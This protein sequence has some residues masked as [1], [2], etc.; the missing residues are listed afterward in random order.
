MRLERVA[1]RHQPERHESAHHVGD[2]LDPHRAAEQESRPAP[3]QPAA[4]RGLALE[5]RLADHHV[6]PALQAAHKVGEEL[7]AVGEIGVHEDRAVALGP[8][9]PL[10]GQVEQLL[11]GAR[12]A[13]P[14]LMADQA[15]GEDLG[16]RVE[17]NSRLVGRG[18]IGQQDLVLAREFLEDLADLPEHE[19]DGGALI[20]ARYAD[21][22]HGQ[23]R[24]WAQER[25]TFLTSAAMRS[26][27]NRWTA[28]RAFSIRDRRRAESSRIC[29]TAPA[30][31]T[32]SPGETNNPAPSGNIS[33][34][35]PADVDATGMPR[36]MASS[37]E[38]PSPSSLELMT[39]RSASAMRPRGSFTWPRK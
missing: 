19:A 29:D 32:G 8:V 15:Q 5:G 25:Y 4:P 28:L 11:H 20:E 6:G 33:G 13:L 38:V 39:K 30:S 27:L 23:S 17:P 34:I 3:G 10:Q 22:N 21:V 24:K 35:P 14:R 16:I 36:A 1:Q 31:A 9:G 18:V 26:A 7:R 37:T 2:P 12:V